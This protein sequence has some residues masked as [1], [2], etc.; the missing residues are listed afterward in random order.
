MT[1]VMTE[2]RDD[3]PP[4]PDPNFNPNVFSEDEEE[5][6]TLEERKRFHPGTSDHAPPI[7]P[8]SP[9]GNR[10]SRP[11][12]QISNHFLNPDAL[13]LPSSA[14]KPTMARAE[15]YEDE[16]PYVELTDIV[17]F[18]NSDSL[19]PHCTS[20]GG[21]AV[22][23][24]T[25]IRSST[26]SQS[27][28]T[29]IGQ[30]YS[31]NPTSNGQNRHAVSPLCCEGS[32]P[33]LQSPKNA[34]APSDI[35][36]DRPPIQTLVSYASSD[37]SSTI[38]NVQ[39]VKSS[40]IAEHSASSNRNGV[41]LNLN[42]NLDNT[43]LPVSMKKVD[44][45][46]E[47]SKF[48]SSND[49]RDVNSKN[50]SNSKEP[51]TVD[52]CNQLSGKRK[53]KCTKPNVSSVGM[54]GSKEIRYID[55]EQ[56][57]DTTTQ[58][59]SATTLS[60]TLTSVCITDSMVR[61]CSV[62]YLDLVD[63][64]L[65]PCDIALHML[66][67]DAPKRLVLVNRKNKQKKNKKHHANQDK[68]MKSGMFQSP[69]LKNC[70]KS[71]SLDSSDL[72]PMPDI[73]T[74]HHLPNHTEEISENQANNNEINTSLANTTNKNSEPVV[75]PN[76]K[77]DNSKLQ[78]FS[79]GKSPISKRKK[80]EAENSSSSN[81]NK[82]GSNKTRGRSKQTNSPNPVPN[83]STIEPNPTG[84][85]TRNSTS[86]HT[87]AL[88]TLE[89]LLTRLR[90]LDD[91][92]SSPP[93]SP[94]LP[95]SSP[96]SPAPTKKGKRPQSASPIR[97]HLLASPLLGRRSRKNKLTESSDDEVPASSDEIVNSKN[98]KDLETFQKAQL[99][100]KVTYIILV[101]CTITHLCAHSYS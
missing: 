4:G 53:E 22:Q 64:Q 23:T 73:Q 38:S 3:F 45:T 88:N 8:M 43:K 16:F 12:S 46:I 17:G 69:K 56:H 60:G 44:V 33:A 58:G 76:N 82:G 101:R 40:L 32:V 52:N 26:T 89:N 77:K 31:R 61:S 79:S 65:V 50:H 39:Q 37:Y 34:V 9:V 98:Y 27:S 66:R 30:T 59:P 74:I 5:A 15:S 78:F 72:F 54:S 24:T 28:T 95:R 55:D 85:P 36:F 63:A 41:S 18:T 10:L 14:V 11:K 6:I 100:Q 21:S 94:R 84:S 92:K 20:T 99:R 80:T 91:N 75:A 62:G 29:I 87:Q 48:I 42:L 7:A 1:L 19:R 51:A 71:K 83:K 93:A 2:L 35:I 47:N 25:T 13:P 70:G 97:K 90:D 68:D 86:L 67:K 49:N 96:A 81:A 57:A